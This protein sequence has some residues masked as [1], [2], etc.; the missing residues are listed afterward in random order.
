MVHF[1]LCELNSTLKMAKIF[2]TQLCTLMCPDLDNYHSAI[3]QLLESKWKKVKSI[4]TI[5]LL[6]SVL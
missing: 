4:K 5:L 1:M 6:D 2:A 3:G